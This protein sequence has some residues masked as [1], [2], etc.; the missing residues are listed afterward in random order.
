MNKRHRHDTHMTTPQKKT[1]Q[2]SIVLEIKIQRWENGQQGTLI[3]TGWYNY[4]IYEIKLSENYTEEDL[5][6][7][8]KLANE[9]MRDNGG[10][11]INH[12]R[13]LKAIKYIIH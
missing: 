4:N 11:D 1:K 7:H 5:D 6:L 8:T 12:W 10:N 9:Y 13:I 3:K 2:T